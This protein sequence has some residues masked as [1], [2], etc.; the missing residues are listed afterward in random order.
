MH[1]FERMNMIWTTD[2]PHHSEHRVDDFLNFGLGQT[3]V[4]Q[5]QSRRMQ[6]FGLGRGG[7]VSRG[8]GRIAHAQLGYEPSGIAKKTFVKM[9]F[10]ATLVLGLVLPTRTASA[11]GA[12]AIVSTR[13]EFEATQVPKSCGD[14]VTFRGLL[15]HWVKPT[16]LSLDAER[17]LTVRI[18]RSQTGGKLADLKLVDTAGSTLAEEH[19][20]FASKT[21]CHKVLWEAAFA[22]A[23]LLGASENPPPVEVPSCP[24]CPSCPS[25]AVCPVCPVPTVQPARVAVPLQSQPVP[26]IM[27][28]ARRAFVGA[29]VFLGM[30]ILPDA[31]LGPHI[32]L[33]FVPSPHSPRIQV[34]LAGAWTMQNLRLTNAAGSMPVHAIPIFGSLCYSRY[35]LRICSGLT[36]SFYQAKRRDLGPGQDELRMTLA[37]NLRMGTEFEIAAPFS[38]RLDASMQLRFWERTFGNELTRLDAQN[39]FGAGGVAM[40]V[41]SFE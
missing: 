32:S 17:R 27:L 14:D 36:T 3:K 12:P 40:G 23:R 22:A 24:A 19:K 33:G 41:W 1:D 4:R 30:G 37:G 26:R 28:A 21:E 34:E 31:A 6:P 11:Q 9:I 2:T 10:F 8:L 16:V 15:T 35:I 18:R 7:F 5:G 29:G 39:P 38:I 13:L 25:C 20:T